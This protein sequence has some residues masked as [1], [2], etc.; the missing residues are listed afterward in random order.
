MS[1]RHIAEHEQ[2]HN[3]PPWLRA[4]MRHR[5]KLSGLSMHDDALLLTDEQ[6]AAMR[7][8]ILDHKGGSPSPTTSNPVATALP[9]IEEG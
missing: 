6:Y 5:F 9:V 3:A 7:S 2:Q 8:A 1:K 4:A